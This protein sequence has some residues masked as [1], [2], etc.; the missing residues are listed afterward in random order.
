MNKILKL[1]EINKM[2][3]FKLNSTYVA[4]TKDEVIHKITSIN[5]YISYTISTH[6]TGYK[7]NE[8][9]GASFVVYNLKKERKKLISQKVVTKEYNG[10][11]VKTTKRVYSPAKWTAYVYRIPQIILAMNNIQVRQG[12]RTFYFIKK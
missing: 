3:L 11:K 9:N 12:Q 7:F 10:K 2:P 1:N 8:I 5:P 6:G 4:R